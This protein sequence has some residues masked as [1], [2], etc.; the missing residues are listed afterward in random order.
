MPLVCRERVDWS[1]C[2]CQIRSD[3]SLPP[4]VASRVPSA[5]ADK[6]LILSVWLCMGGLPVAPLRDWLTYHIV[7]E[8]V[9]MMASRALRSSDTD[10]ARP[11]RSNDSCFV[12]E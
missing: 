6:P 2:T 4:A 8:S 10:R 3:P 5:L 7:P 9:E 11:S 1:S 12:G